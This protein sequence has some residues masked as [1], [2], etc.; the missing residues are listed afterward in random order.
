MQRVAA[1][2]ARQIPL[3]CSRRP[4]LRS[5]RLPPPRLL[6]RDHMAQARKYEVVDEHQDLLS[7]RLFEEPSPGGDGLFRQEIKG[8]VPFRMLQMDGMDHGID[9]VQQ[10]FSR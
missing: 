6:V 4:S 7:G 1:P 8:R 3:W 9:Q 10:L 2:A 5:N